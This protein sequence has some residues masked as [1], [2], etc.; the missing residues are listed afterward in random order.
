ME[1]QFI[2]T[3]QFL[4]G[5]GEMGAL[6]RAADWDGTPVGPV[7]TWPQS[8]RTALNI[9]LR[10][11]YPMFVWWGPDLIHF[12]NDAYSPLMGSRYATSI[13]KGGEEVWPEIWDQLR[14]MA[15]TVFQGE[16]VYGKNVRLYLNRQ[17]F[18]EESYFNFSYSPIIDETGAVGGLFCACHEETETVIQQRR[19]QTFKEL[20]VDVA[21]VKD[22]H[23]AGR[24]SVD[25][26]AKND[27]DIPFAALY[28]LNNDGQ[29]AQLIQSAGFEPDKNPFAAV[30]TLTEA[31]HTVIWPF[32]ETVRSGEPQLLTDLDTLGLAL[33]EMPSGNR[34]HTACTLPVRRAGQNQPMG[35]LICGLSPNRSFD[36][37][38]QQFLKL[39]GTQIATSLSAVTALDEERAFTEIQLELERAKSLGQ[40]RANEQLRQLFEQT[41]V[42]ICILRGPDQVI[43]FANERMCQLWHRPPDEVMGKP[44][45]DVLKEA[46]NA[47]FEEILTSVLTTGETVVRNDMAASLVRNG[48]LET[49]YVSASYQPMYDADGRINSV[50]AVAT[51]VTE[52]FLARRKIEESEARFRQLAD[53]M[54]QIVWTARPDGYLDY[55]NQQWYEYA[56]QDRG[57]GDDGWAFMLHPEDLQRCFDTWS[58]SLRTGEFYQ[59]EFRLDNPRNPGV[60]RWFLTR[61]TAIRNT[62]ANGEPGAIIKWFGTCT[63][64]DE[65][66]RIAELLESRVAE[67][68]QELSRA[69]QNLERSNSELKRSNENLQ[70]FAY[71]ASHDLQEPLRKIQSF[72]DILK[73]QHSSELGEGVDYIDRMK[74]AASRMSML[75]KDLLAFSRITTHRE[76]LAPVSLDKII[77]GVLADLDLIV[78]ESGASVDITPLPIVRGDPSQLGQL[79]QNLLANAIKF[80]RIDKPLRIR[81]DCRTLPTT[82]LPVLIKMTSEASNFYEIS[83]ADNGIGFDEKYVDRIFEVFQRLH[84]RSQY[85]GTGIGLAIVQKV[86]EI[87]G[88]A[89]TASS[90]PGEGAT[91]QIYLPEM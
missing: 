5:G 87:H 34:P 90:Q 72:G 8:L 14:P 82:E 69:N 3:E 67:R 73:A 13:G 30:V 41:P 58:H 21:A 49:I 1:K 89:V 64:I 15:E 27:L 76:A 60:Y 39:V 50:M 2:L 7:E 17:D 11:G 35:V 56:G 70:R 19:L 24:L 51:E 59:I 10:S 18:A 53:S 68:T 25:A 16:Q 46:R 84:G 65:Q 42:A 86:V 79:F 48:K 55:F 52:P 33:P 75:I 47:G 4:A 20:N 77:T 63:D 6:I 43:E 26:L 66:K 38:Y 74:T 78:Q 91:F 37:A 44:M 23:E 80:R 12:H 81:I 40:H 36:D 45:F 71:V 22:R 29:S 61:A 88:G 28:L 83:V 31:G 85:A 62:D 54:P 57:F 32:R 9:I